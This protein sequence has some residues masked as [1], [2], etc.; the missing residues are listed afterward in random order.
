MPSNFAAVSLSIALRSL[1][2]KQGEGGAGFGGW[3][4]W[5]CRLAKSGAASAQ[6]TVSSARPRV[7]RDLHEIDGSGLVDD[8]VRP[9][10]SDRPGSIRR[11]HRVIGGKHLDVRS[12]PGPGAIVFR[13]N[14]KASSRRLP[15]RTIAA[16]KTPPPLGRL[17]P[18]LVERPSLGYGSPRAWSM[19][20]TPAPR[21]AMYR[22]TKQ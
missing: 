2:V 16:A 21:L 9:R 15:S 7:I 6:P 22:N 5:T 18:A 13:L 20:H 8:E 17:P 12:V 1:S 19:L 14:P 3:E 4:G 10:R 11:L